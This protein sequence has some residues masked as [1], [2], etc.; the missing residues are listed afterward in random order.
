MNTISV[1]TVQTPG[2]VAKLL[3]RLAAGEEVAF[4]DRDVA[5]RDAAVF[6][7]QKVEATY[8]LRDV[9]GTTLSSATTFA[10]AWRRRPQSSEVVAP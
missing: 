5:G 6:T 10:E 8:V 7:L 2:G 3:Q 1:D 9:W 4:S